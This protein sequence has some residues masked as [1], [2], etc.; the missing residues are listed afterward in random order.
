MTDITKRPGGFTTCSYSLTALPIVPYLKLNG[1]AS[2]GIAW[3]DVEVSNKIIG[4]D[5]LVVTNQK[6][7]IYSGT[8]NLQP[9]SPARNILDNLI[10]S[11]TPVFGKSLVSYEIILTEKNNFT[12]YTY[13][14]SGGSIMSGQSGN[15]NNLDNGQGIKTYKMQFTLK[16]PLAIL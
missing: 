11:A 2:D 4:A 16:V 13:V 10:L 9:N 8:F 12:G 5:G 15:N 1:F 3:D 7:I 6:P 14:Y